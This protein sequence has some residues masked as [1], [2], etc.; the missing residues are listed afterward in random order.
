MHGWHAIIYKCYTEYEDIDR[1]SLKL[2]V[3]ILCEQRT[4]F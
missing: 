1:A 3:F 2:S 4:E